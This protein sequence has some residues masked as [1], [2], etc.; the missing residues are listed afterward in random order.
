MDYFGKYK[1]KV[2]LDV[3]QRFKDRPNAKYVDVTAITP[4]PL[5][6][7]KTT[8]TCGLSQSPGLPRQEG[9][10]LHP[11]AF[12]GPTFGIKGGAAGGGY[13]Q[14]VPME[15][16]N[17]HLTGDIHAVSAA[18]NLLAAAV[19]ARI[20]HEDELSD[21]KLAKALC[22]D[23]DVRPV[24]VRPA[25]EAGHQG[26]EASRS[27]RPKTAAR[28]FRLDIDPYAI[29][30]NRVVDISDRAIRN[31][32]IGLGTKRRRPA[33]P[34]RLRHHRGQR[35]DGH[36]G[37]GHRPEGP[38]RAHRPHR[39]RHGQAR[40]SPVTA[41]D[42]GV[43]GAMTVL[44]KDALMPNLMQTLER[45]PGLCPRRPLRQHR[46]RQL[47]HRRRP[48]R[49]QAGSDAT[50][51]PS[52]ALA[53][54]AAWRSSWTS[55]AASVGLDPQLRGASSPRS[56]PS[57]C[58]AVGPGWWPASRWTQPTRRRTWSCWRRACANLMPAHRERHKFG[59]PVVVAVNRFTTTPTA[60]SSR[61]QGGHGGR[62]R[63]R[64]AA[65][66]LGQGRRRGAELAEAVMEACE[67][68]SQLQVPLSLRISIKDKIETIA[69]EIYGADGSTTRRRPRPR[70]SC[71]PSSASTSCPSAWPRRTFPSPTIPTARVRRE[72]RRLP[73]RD[74]R[75]S[76]G[77]GFLY[78]LCGDDAHHARPAI[79]S[80]LHGRGH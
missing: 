77:A 30:L 38:A 39:H 52:P 54:T 66:G 7:G 25:Q 49:P 22:P 72:A 17:L 32:V 11:P 34:D 50:W 14:I 56:A 31:I 41:E 4:T 16:F 45:Q 23:G 13:A 18:H 68:P 37:P 10:H 74:I 36:P 78:P 69:K 75:A 71:T 63:R 21:E 15:D 43:A 29:T 55:S 26:R 33:A 73:I 19:D 8:T 9:L 44:M 46:P 28:L 40:R 70:S 57:R 79:P 35:G 67:K 5:G 12:Q 3:L 80:G 24:D 65:A 58:T 20:M 51:S 27:E 60:R 61:P 59:V 2:H 64:R 48:D 53:P 1:A 6:E 76:V 42:L 62:R 47:L